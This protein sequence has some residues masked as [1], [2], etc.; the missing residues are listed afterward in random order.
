MQIQNK[1]TLQHMI[2][3]CFPLTALFLVFSGWVGSYTIP[4]FVILLLLGFTY[5]FVSMIT[6]KALI[7]SIINLYV[8]GI[9]IF[10]GALMYIME[11]ANNV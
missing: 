10:G 7:G 6:K 8:I 1:S 5:S 11:I 9:L 4:V 3:F 2:P